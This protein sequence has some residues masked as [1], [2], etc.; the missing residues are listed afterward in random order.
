MAKANG[1]TR[2]VQPTAA[3]RA[4]NLAD[5]NAKMATGKYEVGLSSISSATG[6]YVAY[7][8]G[9]QYHI[10]EMEAAKHL[11]D[12]GFNVELTPE[13]DGYEMYATNFSGGT[14][15]YSEGT[16]SLLTFEQKTPDHIENT[17]KQT[18][19]GAIKHANTKRSQIALIYDRYSLFHRKD[20]EDGM[21][22]YQKKDKAWRKKV[23]AVIVVNSKGEVY[24][25]RF[26]E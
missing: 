15:K 20:I 3:S 5:F 2:L 26:E 22:W 10:E 9:H 24:E 12:N 18:V 13:G 21:K 8:T 16:V 1:S 19:R 7:M 25:H 14:H 23:K 6:A 4:A 11:A 17:L